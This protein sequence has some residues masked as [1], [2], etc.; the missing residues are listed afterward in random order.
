[1]TAALAD[2]H[3]AQRAYDEALDALGDA[4]DAA[5]KEPDPEL[6]RS[7]VLQAEARLR[8]ARE[9][10]LRAGNSLRDHHRKASPRG[11]RR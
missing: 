1:M 6:G 11:L 4:R 3:E 7:R 5:R 10:L 8:E 9:R 2:L